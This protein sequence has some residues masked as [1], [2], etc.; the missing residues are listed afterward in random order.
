MSIFDW[1][2][3]AGR[4]STK[5][6]PLQRVMTI[7]IPILLHLGTWY[8][9]ISS[10]P[11]R[12]GLA[13]WLTVANDIWTEVACRTFTQKWRVNFSRSTKSPLPCDDNH[14]NIYLYILRW[15]LWH[16]VLLL[17][18]MIRVQ[19]S[20]N[21]N[22]CTGHVAWTKISLCAINQ[23][24][25]GDCLLLQRN[26]DYLDWYTLTTLYKVVSS[27]TSHSPAYLQN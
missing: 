19:L 6:S 8:D 17:T 15:S 16:P 7:N 2:I 9:W 27:A 25:F 3:L 22:I 14:G 26:L 13:M 4:V 18:I 23:L 24:K 20:S 5:M 1:F 21:P 10:P 12:L 11:L